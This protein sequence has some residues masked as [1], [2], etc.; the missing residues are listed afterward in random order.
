SLEPVVQ[1]LQLKANAGLSTPNELARL[2]DLSN[3]L[4]LTLLK[5]A[6]ELPSATVLIDTL[7]GGSEDDELFGSTRAD[8][9]IGDAG[10][11]IIHHSA[12]ADTVFGDEGDLD[13]YVIDGT[14]D[15]DVIT[16]SGAGV[17]VRGAPA[18]RADHSGIEVVGVSALAGDDT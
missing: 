9:L 3:D 17:S 7:S 13:R 8:T 10:N 15:N 6:S 4:Q 1:E 14:A 12:G 16:V 18:I 2:R 11:D 5:Q